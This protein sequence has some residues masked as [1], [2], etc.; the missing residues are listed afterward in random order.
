MSK[1]IEERINEL[2]QEIN[3][4]AEVV[5]YQYYDRESPH[6]MDNERYSWAIKKINKVFDEEIEILRNTKLTTHD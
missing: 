2:N 6:F 5:N 3:Q 1:E 4:R